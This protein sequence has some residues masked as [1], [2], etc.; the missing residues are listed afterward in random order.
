MRWPN[1]I[2]DQPAEG[3][4]HREAGDELASGHGDA[5]RA[6]SDEDVDAQERG[7]RA[8][9]DVSGW[10]TRNQVLDDP[11]L[12]LLHVKTTAKKPYHLAKINGSDTKILLVL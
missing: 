2:A 8:Q 9:R 12:P 5:E 10:R 4:A 7:E 1:Q 3:R 11:L 6:D